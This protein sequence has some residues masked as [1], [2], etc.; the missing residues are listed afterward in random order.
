MITYNY[1]LDFVLPSESNTTQWIQSTIK[2]KGFDL[3]EINY[4]FCDDEYLL[5]L[6]IAYLNHDTLTDILSFDNTIGKTL[7][8]DIFISIERVRDNA[9]QYHTTFA[10]ELY[11]VMIH[12]ILH[13]MGFK[14]KT[15]Q[16]SLQMRT[17]ENLALSLVN[18]Y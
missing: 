18:T 1:E 17:E 13:F 5:K 8:G 10:D 14:D 2:K 11:R 7:S 15:D 3:G 4:I 16:E 9:H 12:G 6:N